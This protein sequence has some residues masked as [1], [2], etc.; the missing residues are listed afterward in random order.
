MAGAAA[1]LARAGSRERDLAGERSPAA[2][3]LA[4][5][6]ASEALLQRRRDEKGA[7]RRGGGGDARVARVAPGGDDAGVYFVPDKPGLLHPKITEFRGSEHEVTFVERLFKWATVLTKMTVTFN[8]LVAESMSKKQYRIL[9][10]FSRPEICMEFYT[11]N[12]DMV[13]EM[14]APKD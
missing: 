2:A 10:S 8:S 13:E 14:Y 12:E 5:Q 1:P 7:W 9:R 4:G 11:S 3:F 6:R